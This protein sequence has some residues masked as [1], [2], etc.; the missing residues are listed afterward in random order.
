MTYTEK[1]LNDAIAGGFSPF[2]HV[3]IEELD[4]AL[5]GNTFT[6]RYRQPESDATHGTCTVSIETLM[7]QPAYW[8]GVAVTRG[9]ALDPENASARHPYWKVPAGIFWQETMDGMP[10]E[11]VLAR[12]EDYPGKRAEL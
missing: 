8:K 12:L 1:A 2:P 11:Q 10:H 9:W 4:C 7:M 6:C 3:S 5:D